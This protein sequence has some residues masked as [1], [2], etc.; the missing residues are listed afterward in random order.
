MLAD[1]GTLVI[2]AIHGLGSVGKSTVAAALAHDPKIKNHFSDGILWATLGQEPD[3]LS[4]LG[5]WVQGLG[6][7]NYR[8]TNIKATSAYLN[9]LLSQ[10][11]VLLVVDDAWIDKNK[12]WKHV[13]AFK[14]GG[15]RC[16]MLVTT[17]DASVAT[18]LNA[19]PYYLDVMTKTQS[20]DLLR[21]KAEHL[22]KPLQTSEIKLAK[23]LAKAVGYLPLA[24][25]LA[26]AQ[27][28]S[29]TLWQD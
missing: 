27:V 2:S 1:G 7:Y 24:L 15:S 26:A 22:G 23:D 3:V 16:G 4:L 21:K 11:K 25:E 19:S 9:T 12:G 18:S 5:G 10:K 13:E 6:D 20:L 14:V 28:A 17:R 29:G 8:A